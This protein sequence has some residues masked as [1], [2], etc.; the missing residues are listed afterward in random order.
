MQTLYSTRPNL[1]LGFHGCDK[2]LAEDVVLGKTTLKPSTND[3]DWLGW[4]IYLQ[5]RLRE[6]GKATLSGR[7]HGQMRHLLAAGYGN[8]PFA[9]CSKKANRCM[10]AQDFARK[11]MCKSVYVIPIVSRVTSCLAR[12]TNNSPPD[13]AQPPDCLLAPCTVWTAHTEGIFHT[14]LTA[15]TQQRH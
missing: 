14:V 15:K 6:L 1:L 4:G 8:P 2:Q 13:K 10:R 12:W 11:A 9:V 5:H 3:Y 7:R